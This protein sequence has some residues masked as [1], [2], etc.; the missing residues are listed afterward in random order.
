HKPDPCPSLWHG[1]GRERLLAEASE[2][3]RFHCY[4]RNNTHTNTPA[5]ISTPAMTTVRYCWMRPDCTY[6]NALL[7]PP[8]PSTTSSAPPLITWVSKSLLRSAHHSVPRATKCR[9]PSIRPRSI[10]S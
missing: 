2:G 10:S 9:K 6:L 4:R 7:S 8:I 5:S 1:E 3:L